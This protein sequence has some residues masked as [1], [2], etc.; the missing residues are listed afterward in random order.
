MF[1]YFFILG[2][3]FLIMSGSLDEFR[4]NKFLSCSVLAII[5]ILSMLPDV[6][7]KYT[8]YFSWAGAFIMAVTLFMFLIMPSEHM[9]SLLYA[10]TLGLLVWAIITLAPNFNVWYFK[11]VMF[12]IIGAMLSATYFQGAVISAFACLICDI[13]TMLLTTDMELMTLF[14]FVGDT[15]TTVII[16][17]ILPVIIMALAGKK[18]REITLEGINGASQ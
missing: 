12:S 13:F 16:S 14:F 5:F 11:A 10:T 6:G 7:I 17:L 4:I 18:K 2:T 15:K 1:E 9:A 8:V 3:M